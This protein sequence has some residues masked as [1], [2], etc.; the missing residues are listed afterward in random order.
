MNEA[1]CPGT[2]DSEWRLFLNSLERQP[3]PDVNVD[4]SE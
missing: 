4:K 2:F 3:V 1:V